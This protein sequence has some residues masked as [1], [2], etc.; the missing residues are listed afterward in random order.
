MMGRFNVPSNGILEM[1]W[2]W[3]NIGGKIGEI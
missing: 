1:E 3:E 2:G